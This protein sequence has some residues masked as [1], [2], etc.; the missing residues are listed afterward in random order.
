MGQVR[1]CLE[2]VLEA[3][4]ERDEGDRDQLG[5]AVD[6]A[7]QVAEIDPP[8]PRPD[9]AYVHAARLQR[10]VEVERALEVERVGHD[11]AATAAEAEAGDH[12]VLARHRARHVSDLKGTGVDDCGEVFPDARRHLPV[13]L[14]RPIGPAF[15]VV[16]DGAC[17]L[18]AHRMV[19]GVVQVGP[20]LGEREIGLAGKGG[21]ARRGRVRSLRR[22]DRRHRS[23]QPLPAV[24]RGHR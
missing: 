21:D 22:G 16:L 14:L 11:V 6:R 19:A 20:A 9:H 17:G 23:R 2:I 13:R 8:L 12:E 7:V 5:V 15:E 1:H 3:V 24:H 10:S 4:Q 18:D